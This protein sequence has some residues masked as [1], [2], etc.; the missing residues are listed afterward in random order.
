MCRVHWNPHTEEDS[1]PHTVRL[2]A[3]RDG[4]RGLA[5]KSADRIK[6]TRA[7]RLAVRDLRKLRH[8]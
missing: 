1:L 2:L 6:V 3:Q 4:A 5:C 7:S 8:Q